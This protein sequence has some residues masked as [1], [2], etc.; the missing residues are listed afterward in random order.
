VGP[1]GEVTP[2]VAW[3]GKGSSG[4]DRC[5]VFRIH[6]GGSSVSPAGAGARLEEE[7]TEE[8]DTTGMGKTTDA[9]NAGAI[10]NLAL[11]CTHAAVRCGPSTGYCTAR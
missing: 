1:A 6:C 11:P 9:S 8:N 2:G 4:Q 7:S 10:P 5:F 3:E